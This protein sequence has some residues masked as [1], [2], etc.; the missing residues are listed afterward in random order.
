[1]RKIELTTFEKLVKQWQ[2]KAN[3]Q[4]MQATASFERNQMNTYWQCGMQKPIT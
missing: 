4:F 1:M 3:R 2:G